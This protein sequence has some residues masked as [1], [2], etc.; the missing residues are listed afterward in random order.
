MRLMPGQAPFA[1]RCRIDHER[2]TAGNLSLLGVD[3]LSG[4]N[5]RQKNSGLLLL[6]A[7]TESPV[8][9]DEAL[10]LV[11]ARLCQRELCGEER[12][13]A[14]QHFEIVGGASA[15][16]HDG[17]SDRLRQ[18]VYHLLLLNSNFTEF[19]VTDQRIGY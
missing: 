17:Q 11:A 6:P 1:P 18:V 3:D 13:L 5:G 10:I 19:L 15:I 4:V 9:L 14:V 2:R 7:A 8:N 16:A 12:A